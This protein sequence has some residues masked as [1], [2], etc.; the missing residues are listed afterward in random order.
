M[1]QDGKPQLNFFFRS[2][3][4][5]E[6]AVE[7]EDMEADLEAGMIAVLSFLEICRRDNGFGNSSGL[8]IGNGEWYP[9]FFSFWYALVE[10]EYTFLFPLPT[11]C[12]FF[13]Q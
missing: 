9:P 3:E 10:S 12:V 13:P 8:S 2:A 6:L 1:P 4:Y 11:M 5:L 7:A